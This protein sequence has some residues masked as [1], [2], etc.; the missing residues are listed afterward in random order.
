MAQ[1]TFNRVIMI[2]SGPTAVMVLACETRENLPRKE[3]SMNPFF[4]QKNIILTHIGIGDSW[5][6]PTCALVLNALVVFDCNAHDIP[7]MT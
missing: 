4:D 2:I 6:L 1:A 7:P 5:V 3:I